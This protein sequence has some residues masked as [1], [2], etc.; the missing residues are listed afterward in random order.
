MSAAAR[1]GARWGLPLILI[2]ALG[3]VVLVLTAVSVLAQGVTVMTAIA[4]G[5]C[6]L[7]LLGA[8][9]FAISGYAVEPDAIVVFHP[10]W[11]RR[12]DRAALVSAEPG[13]E[14][15]QGSLRTFGNGGLF[16]F[17]GRYRSASLGGY[18]AYVTDWADAVV[19]RFEHETVVI[20]PREPERFLAELAGSESSA[21]VGQ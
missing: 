11:R 10:G 21:K 6:A 15:T 19:L 12:F 3:S 20:S 9:P 13:Q 2:S 17:S 8:V 4:A 14:A 5:I 18:R 7:C 1:Y 16:S